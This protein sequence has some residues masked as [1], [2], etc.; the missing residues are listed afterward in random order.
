MNVL[1]RIILAFAPKAGLNRLR[2]RAAAEMLIQSR[3]YDI[4]SDGRRNNG[5]QRGRSTGASE[6]SKAAD[7]AAT[8]AQELV[9]NTAFGKRIKN[10]WASNIVGTGIRAEIMSPAKAGK[11]KANADWNA[12]AESTQCDFNGRTNLYGIQWLIAATMVESGGAIVR[13]HTGAGGVLKLQVLEQAMLDKAVSTPNSAG[14]SVIDGI[15]YSADGVEV[16]CHI[17]TNNM[18][19]GKTESDKTIYLRHYLDYVRVYHQER[20]GQ[21]LGVSWLAA[22]ATTIRKYDTLVDAKLMQDQIAACL[23]VFVEDAEGRLGVSSDIDDQVEELEPG[24]VNYVR[25]GT[26]VHTITPPSS[27]GSQAFMET[28]RNDVAIGAGLAGTQL[29]GDYSKLNFASGRMSKIEFFITL[30]HVQYVI[31]KVALDA[32]AE[33][34]KALYSLTN[35]TRINSMSFSWTMPPRGVVQPKEELE[36]AIMKARNGI[37]S[38]SSVAKAF[39]GKPLDEII[40]QWQDDKKAFGDMSF[41]IDP[42]K[43]SAAGN[44]LNADDAASSNS[45]A[46]G[47]SANSSSGTDQNGDS[48][49]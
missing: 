41:D 21:H 23:G 28:I 36:T 12:W 20:A 22:S 18:D 15:E 19:I 2:N 44:Q 10:I 9:R 39:S 40:A 26:K 7:I 42:S 46:D 34:F 11:K 30:D 29:T 8:R 17:K 13:F 48:Q 49:P 4:A 31:M 43:F 24:M 47:S 32:I 45:N 5:W 16:G 1:D 25:A 35:S 33:R 14:N 37:D 6:A 3:G 38:P 27:Q